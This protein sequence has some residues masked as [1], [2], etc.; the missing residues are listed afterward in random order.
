MA[1]EDWPQLTYLWSRAVLLILW[2][3]HFIHFLRFPKRHP[4]V[5][6]LIDFHKSNCFSCG[7]PFFQ[8]LHTKRCAW[9]LTSI[10]TLLSM[11]HT[12]FAWNNLIT[13]CWRRWAT[14][15]IGISG[16][17]SQ[18]LLHTSHIVCWGLTVTTTLWQLLISINL[19]D[20]TFKYTRSLFINDI[21]LRGGRP[22]AMTLQSKACV[23]S[24][25]T[26]CRVP[27]RFAVDRKGRRTKNTTHTHLLL[28]N[29]NLDYSCTVEALKSYLSQLGFHIASSFCKSELRNHE[30]IIIWQTIFDWYDETV[31]GS[32]KTEI[33]TWHNHWFMLINGKK[34]LSEPMCGESIEHFDKCGESP[35]IKAHLVTNTIAMKDLD[36]ETRV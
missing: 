24:T 2:K 22:S 12:T 13:R 8:F 16:W 11:V 21:T 17:P 1:A 23:I 34:N 9:C 31:I 36:S 18:I 26:L 5:H 33:Y 3:N 25:L 30:P 27:S 6:S 14:T 20:F 29:T 4:C 28:L 32:Y 7:V 15:R 35:H 19:I 10:S